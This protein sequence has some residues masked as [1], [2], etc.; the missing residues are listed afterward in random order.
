[1][2]RWSP[3]FPGR[4]VDF[5]DYCRLYE[6]AQ[7]RRPGTVFAYEPMW[8]NADGSIYPS[9]TLVVAAWLEQPGYGE[10]EVLENAM[11]H[12]RLGIVG[13]RTEAQLRTIH[14]AGHFMNERALKAAADREVDLVR[15]R[16]ERRA[17][18]RDL[19]QYVLKK[20]PGSRV[21][22]RMVREST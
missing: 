12:P 19:G 8:T 6:R 10:F 20:A 16:S 7:D 9:D 4:L 1:M 2:N 21:G 14:N 17:A 5:P 15:G 18:R 13:L 11:R 3:D 22:R